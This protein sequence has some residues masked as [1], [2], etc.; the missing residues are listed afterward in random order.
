M[1]NQDRE[2]KLVALWLNHLRYAL[3]QKHLLTEFLDDIELLNWAKENVVQ[4]VD[5][6]EP[7]I[8]KIYLK[9]NRLFLFKCDERDYN[10]Q[11]EFEQ[12]IR[13]N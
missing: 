8:L 12:E 5:E 13:M 9:S 6:N 10:F 4:V 3:Y 1:K 11:I 2:N 7:H